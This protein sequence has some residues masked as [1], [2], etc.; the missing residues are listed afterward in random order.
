MRTIGTAETNSASVIAAKAIQTVKRC[1]TIESIFPRGV[2][3]R[4]EGRECKQRSET[5]SGKRRIKSSLSSL[6]NGLVQRKT[7]EY[8]RLSSAK[9]D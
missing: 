3:Q 4:A 5:L 1:M 2:S 8:F 7:A 6:L 9:N